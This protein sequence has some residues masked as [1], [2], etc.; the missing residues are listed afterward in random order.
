MAEKHVQHVKGAT[1]FQ[2]IALYYIF[3]LLETKGS[4]DSSL[5]L[6]VT[7]Q[8]GLRSYTLICSKTAI[9]EPR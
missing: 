6:C 9:P 1:S 2:L 5:P 3:E 4:H 7:Q 8:V